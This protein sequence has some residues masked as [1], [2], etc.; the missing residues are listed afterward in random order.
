MIEE[1]NNMKKNMF[2][3]GGP[4]KSEQNNPFFNFGQAFP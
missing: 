3:Y 2:P 4:L 1:E